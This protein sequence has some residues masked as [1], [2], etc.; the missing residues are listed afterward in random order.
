MQK[1]IAMDVTDA[2]T[3]LLDSFIYAADDDSQDVNIIFDGKIII[4]TRA[5][6]ERAKSYNAFK[7]I[8]FHTEPLYRMINHDI[9]FTKRLEQDEILS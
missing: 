1:P 8:I 5:R 7:S 3:N 6:K 4:G 2:K 9:L